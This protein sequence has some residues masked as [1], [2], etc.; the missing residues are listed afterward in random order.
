MRGDV[1][2]APL[3]T[4]KGKSGQQ[5]GAFAMRQ[6][7]WLLGQARLM[8]RNET[9]AEDLVQEAILRFIQAF[10]TVETLPGERTCASWLITTL[11]NLFYDQCR[12]R[13]VQANGAK[14]PLLSEEPV[15]EHE[16]SAPTVYDTITDEQFAQALHALSP[17]MRA[18][19]ELHAAGKKYQDI[20]RSL[21]IPVGTVSKRLHDARA[22]LRE[23]LQRALGTEVQ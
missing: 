5:A 18:T 19:F 7:D 10:D 8:C 20:A 14:D 12:R 1:K 4:T 15:V 23:L 16:P 2:A 21:D 6:R 11:T 3:P 9:D 17:K 13:R 22:K